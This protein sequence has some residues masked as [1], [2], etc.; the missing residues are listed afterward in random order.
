MTKQ[1]SNAMFTIIYCVY[2]HLRH[3]T[4]KSRTILQK[5]FNKSEQS[6]LMCQSTL[7]T[8]AKYNYTIIV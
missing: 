7:N 2:S 1:L 3:T 4:I 6:S 8:E 5:Y